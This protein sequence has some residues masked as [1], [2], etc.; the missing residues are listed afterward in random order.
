MKFASA[1]N[2]KDCSQP[3]GGNNI[4]ENDC[5]NILA[6]NACCKSS[7]VNIECTNLPT[8]RSHIKIPHARGVT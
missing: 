1:Y 2:P 8:A 5:T 4:F 6:G 7:S 3:Q